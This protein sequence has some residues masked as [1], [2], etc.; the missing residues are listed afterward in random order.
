[1]LMACPACASPIA[2][3]ARACPRCGHRRRPV[4]DALG[5]WRYVLGAVLLALALVVGFWP[6]WPF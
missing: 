6:S 3:T 4:L 5:P 1:M 2:V